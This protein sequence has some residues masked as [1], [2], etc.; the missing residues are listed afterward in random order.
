[1]T[2]SQ[3]QLVQ[4][5][6]DGIASVCFGR[7]T[8]LLLVA[9][10]DKTLYLY[11]ASDNT[12][13]NR[14]A[15]QNAVLSCAFN[16][17]DSCAFS[18]GLDRKVWSSDIETGSQNALGLHEKPIRC[19]SFLSS[20][21]TVVSGSWDQT[22]RQWDPRDK[23]PVGRYVLEGRVYGMDC[24]KDKIIVGLDNRKV[25]LFDARNMTQP[26]Q[27]RDPCLKHQTRCI[28]ASSDG[29]QYVV[30]SI[31]GRVAVEFVNPSPETQKRKYAFKCHRAKID[32]NPVIYPVN[33]IAFHPIY[34]T[35]AT[36]GCDGAVHVWDGENRKRLVTLPKYETSISSIDFSHD[37][38]LL[39]V[40]ASYTFE[41]GVQE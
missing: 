2:S 26:Q 10:W 25:L 41:H 28:R 1:M 27:I 6:K 12:F 18:G 14:F 13:L 17:D 38:T 8:N 16:N 24:T 3:F 39:A 9:S 23:E 35:F 7:K 15:H 30:S 33:C 37:G 20:T 40:A 5:P 29:S 19:V 4:P 34:G 21:Q 11:K 32:G 36:G 22:I 31:E